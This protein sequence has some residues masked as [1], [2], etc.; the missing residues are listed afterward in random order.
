LKEI[1]HAVVL[2]P[3]LS[4]F[5]AGRTCNFPTEFVESRLFDERVATGLSILVGRSSPYDNDGLIGFG[6]LK[7]RRELVAWHTRRKAH[8]CPCCVLRCFQRSGR[9]RTGLHLCGHCSSLRHVRWDCVVDYCLALCE[10]MRCAD[11]AKENCGQM[12]CAFLNHGS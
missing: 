9:P 3:C 4:A 5:G 2:E 11:C 6:G 8:E 7:G 10:S 12:K 1:S